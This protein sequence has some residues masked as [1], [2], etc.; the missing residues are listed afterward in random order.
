V[1]VSSATDDSDQSNNSATQTWTASNPAPT[2]SNI[3][4]S[5]TTLTDVNH[6]LVNIGLTYTVSDNCDVA[7]V[8]VVTVTSN[9]SNDGKGDGHTAFDSVVVDNH[10]VQVRAERSG[11][12]SSDRVYTITVTATDSAGSSTSRSAQ[13]S[14]PHNN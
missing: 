13:V 9:Q 11:T 3:V 7:I 14:V 8:P 1:S 6:K 5:K 2:V 10:L 4:L 12:S